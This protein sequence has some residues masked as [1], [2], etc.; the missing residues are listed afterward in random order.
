MPI[1]PGATVLETLRAYGVRTPRSAAGAPHHLPR[2][3]SAAMRRC[4]NRGLEAQ[5]LARIGA[6][7]GV[8]RLPDQADGEY[9][10]PAARGRRQRGRRTVRGGMEGSEAPS[11]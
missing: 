2:A 9:R 1:L 6:A 5:A 3:W 7:D 4:P 10:E 11:P 8:A